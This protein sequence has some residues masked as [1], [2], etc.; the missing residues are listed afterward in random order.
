M[1]FNLIKMIGFALLT[2]LIEDLTLLFS[3]YLLIEVFFLFLV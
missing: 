1:F 2:A 3:L